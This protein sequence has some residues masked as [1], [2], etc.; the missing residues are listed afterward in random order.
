MFI[1][2]TDFYDLE[3][4]DVY[5]TELDSEGRDVYSRDD[6]Q[7]PLT[8]AHPHRLRNKHILY[9][10]KVDIPS[11]DRAL[12]RISADDYYKLYINGRFVAQGPSPSY[13]F[14]YNYNEIDIR[15]FL[16]DGENLIAVHTLYQGLIN[17]VWQSGDLRHGLI[18]DV[19]V[20]GA[21]VL[22]SDE[23][24]RVKDHTAYSEMG[25]C[26]YQTQFL[27]RYDSRASEIGFERVS[28]RP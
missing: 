7:D 10:K 13:H 3:P 27:E 22:S 25:I 14:Q 26:G 6:P 16:V 15:E 12:L 1:S 8:V 20:D 19:V 5:H 23:S 28:K 21:V 17:R 18:C 24:F 2:H 11:F 9:R 4:I